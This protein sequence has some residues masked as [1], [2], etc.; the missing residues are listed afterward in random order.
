MAFQSDDQFWFDPAHRHTNL[1]SGLTRKRRIMLRR[2]AESA[3]FQSSLLDM[4]RRFAALAHAD[5]NPQARAYLPA[6]FN[7]WLSERSIVGED[8]DALRL[9]AGL[10]DPFKGLEL[11]REYGT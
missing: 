10:G 2:V 3:V 9:L 11:M 5:S 6:L 8:A 7:A 4:Y 1:V